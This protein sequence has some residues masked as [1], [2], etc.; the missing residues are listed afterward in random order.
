MRKYFSDVNT[1]TPQIVQAWWMRR[2][3]SRAATWKSISCLYVC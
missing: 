2:S 3:I 1:F